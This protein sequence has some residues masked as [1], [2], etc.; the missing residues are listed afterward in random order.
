ML[1]RKLQTEAASIEFSETSAKR[2]EQ[3]ALRKHFLHSAQ[4]RD[5]AKGKRMIAGKHSLS[6]GGGKNRPWQKFGKLV[7]SGCAV[8]NARSTENCGRATGGNLLAGLC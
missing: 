1:W 4:T 2:D 5:A 7:D 8:A 6:A 3:I